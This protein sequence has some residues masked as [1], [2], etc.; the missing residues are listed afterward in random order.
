M[1]ARHGRLEGAL[2]FGHKVSGYYPQLN[3]RGWL[4][5]V[6]Q[7]SLEC[8]KVETESFACVQGLNCEK[9]RSILRGS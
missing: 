5:P 9:G 2:A 6:I 1:R 4:R 3:L 7:N 8:K